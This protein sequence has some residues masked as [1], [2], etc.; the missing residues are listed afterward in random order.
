MSN[1]PARSSAAILAIASTLVFSTSHAS[2]EELTP[3]V[4]PSIHHAPIASAR[5]HVA[6]E[7]T[8]HLSV[9]QRTKRVLVLYRVGTGAL[10]EREL[11]RTIGD[12]W[13]VTIP[14][15][16]VNASGLAYA[17]EIE[18]IDGGRI[19]AF[20][21][22][23]APHPVD[24]PDDSDDV[25]EH[26]L[27]DRLGGRRSVVSSTFDSVDFGSVS[28][29]KTGSIRDNYYRIESAYTYRP[30]TT[31]LEFQIR[32]GLVR[33][34][35]A[36]APDGTTG[37]ITGRDVGLN[38]A[39]PSVVFRLADLAHLEVGVLASVTEVG[40]S[41]GASAALH[42][43]DFYGTKLVLGGETIDTFGSRF[44]TRLDLVRGRAIRISP[45]VEVTNMPH[46]DTWG[47]RLLTE[48]AGN[49]GGGFGVNA[50]IGYQARDFASGGVGLGVGASY[51]F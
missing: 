11:L 49:L 35:S 32:A 14:A 21:S 1:H 6:L 50:R 28:D 22:R 12:A 5:A 10:H 38:Y 8:A 33:G 15:E 41:T 29:G 37:A 46:S 3:P 16:E 34:S 42:L 25:R 39:A 19:A 48:V 7:L 43:G 44:Y 24:V 9:P 31:V 23:D 27:L 20:A 51:A 26:A 18:A 4:I 36:G 40:F 13:A 45:V 30:L 47:V 17:I 2:A